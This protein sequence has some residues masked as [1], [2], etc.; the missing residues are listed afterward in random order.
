VAGTLSTAWRFV[1][2]DSASRQVGIIAGNAVGTFLIAAVAALP[3]ALTS[4]DAP[5]LGVRLTIGVAL[6]FV[7]IPVFMLLATVGRLSAA[8]RDARLMALR[9]LGLRPSR[10]LAV[11]AVENGLLSLAGALAGVAIFALAAPAASAAVR[12]GPGWFSGTLALSP[13]WLAAIALAAG[14]FSAVLAAAPARRLLEEPKAGRPRRRG[15]GGWWRLGLFGFGAAE[16][17]WLGFEPGLSYS[18]RTWAVACGVVA[19]LVGLVLSVPLF[20]VRVAAALAKSRRTVVQLAGR[21]IQAEP[22]SGA[23]LVLGLGAVVFLA[24][25]LTGQL[26]RMENSSAIKMGQRL[27]GDGPQLL[28]MYQSSD[29]WWPQEDWD[30]LG[31]PPKAF[32]PGP[33]S[34]EIPAA[35]PDGNRG[36]E[37]TA[38]RR[39]RRWPLDFRRGP[40]PGRSPHLRPGQP[41]LR[42]SGVCRHLRRVGLVQPVHDRLQRSGS[43]LAG[44]RA[45]LQFVQRRRLTPKTEQRHP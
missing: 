29:D 15:T 40:S 4:D 6:I 19:V 32:V 24:V 27:L 10:T 8:T 35:I 13:L 26:W 37:G 23:R 16:L 43:P 44:D 36:R 21:G 34:E 5:E 18:Q 12:N 25:A 20:S 7:A 1:R 11:A 9:L 17:V 2:A 14:L 28:V 39:C 22:T 42:R 33:D 38:R 31:Y 41:L 3:A 30:E 45:G